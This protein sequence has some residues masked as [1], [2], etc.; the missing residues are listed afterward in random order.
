MADYFARVEL[1]GATWP[2]AYKGLHEALA[3]HGFTNCIQG[4]AGEVRLPT[5]F[6]YSTGRTDDI[7]KVA[8]AVKNCAD[9]TGYKN[10]VMVVRNG[11]WQGY[12]SSKC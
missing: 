4:I 3:K 11:G 2:D 12:L 1:H 5:A 8:L 10:E 9:A 7:D 6:Y